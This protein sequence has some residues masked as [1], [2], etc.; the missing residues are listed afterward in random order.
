MKLYYSPGACSLSPH[1]VLRE[2][3]HTFDLEKVDLGAKKT[4]NGFDYLVIN[5]KGYVPALELSPGKVLTEGP[6]II[7]YLADQKPAAKLAPANGTFERYQLQETLNFL[8]SEIHKTFGPLFTKTTPD[9]YRTIAME[10]LTKRFGILDKHL[11]NHS[12]IF[13][14]T[15]SVADAYAF[16]LANWAPFVKLDLDSLPNVKSYHGRIAARPHVQAA[17]KAEGLIK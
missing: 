8:T 4:E 9:A 5:P 2:A 1:I 13:G 15:F 11:A 14:D 3:G 12:Y 6:A 7:Q 10:N 17:L 16:T